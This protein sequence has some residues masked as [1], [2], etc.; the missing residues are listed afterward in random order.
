M[1][2]KD[3][4]IVQIRDQDELYV[5]EIKSL[6][7]KIVKLERKLEEKHLYEEKY[8]HLFKKLMD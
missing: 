8:N 7:K 5:K 4:L 3:D 2:N 6:K 1:N